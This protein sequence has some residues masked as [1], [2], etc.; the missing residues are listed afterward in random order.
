[1][2]KY[3]KNIIIEVSKVIFL[4]WHNPLV[5]LVAMILIIA[6]LNLCRY[7]L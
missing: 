5:L 6:I 2:L 7:N 1:M 3:I 4:P